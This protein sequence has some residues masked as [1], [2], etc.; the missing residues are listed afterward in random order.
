M[1]E[2]NSVVCFNG[3]LCILLFYNV[4]FPSEIKRDHV[5][6]NHLR[7]C[8]RV[9]CLPLLYPASTYY[10]LKLDQIPHQMVQFIIIIY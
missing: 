3:S 4:F 7:Y 5:D 10:M 2:K 1:L 6:N 8:D 9:R